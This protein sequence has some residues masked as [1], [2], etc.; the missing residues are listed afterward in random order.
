MIGLNYFELQ[1]PGVFHGNETLRLLIPYYIL[2]SPPS[3]TRYWGGK[4]AWASL[5]LPEKK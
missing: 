4:L 5:D 3:Y 1:I 2:A